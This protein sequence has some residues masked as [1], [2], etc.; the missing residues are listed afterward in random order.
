MNAASGCA[1][2]DRLLGRLRVDDDHVGRMADR[3]PVILEIEQAGRPLGQHVEAFAQLL[4][5]IDLQHVGI[6]VGDA[7]QRAIAVGRRRVE[8]VVGGEQF[9]P[10]STRR[11]ASATPRRTL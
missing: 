7:D 2:G 10:C 6:E 4:G 5:A 3:E 9:T 1:I 11:L 8:D